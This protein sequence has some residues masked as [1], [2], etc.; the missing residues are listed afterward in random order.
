MS[1][2][3]KAD[4]LAMFGMDEIT[5]VTD[6]SNSGVIDNVIL[7]VA[8]DDASSEQ[9]SARHSAITIAHTAS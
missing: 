7:Q 8:L 1:Y 6:R 5:Q 3:V 9:H 4:M 2:A